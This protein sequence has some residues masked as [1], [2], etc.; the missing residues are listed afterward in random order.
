M[1]VNSPQE[2]RHP[3]S[4]A[5]I[6]GVEVKISDKLRRSDSSYFLQ[7]EVKCMTLKDLNRLDTYEYDFAV[8]HFVLQNFS[9]DDVKNHSPQ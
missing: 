8:E 7:A 4:Y 9:T 6:D 1:S 2:S 5:E 3:T